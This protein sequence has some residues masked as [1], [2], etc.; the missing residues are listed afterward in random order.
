MEWSCV[1][2]CDFVHVLIIRSVCPFLSNLPSIVVDSKPVIDQHKH[3]LGMGI[4]V[5]IPFG[6]RLTKYKK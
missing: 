2:L 6:K 4:T 1:D 5:L 3:G